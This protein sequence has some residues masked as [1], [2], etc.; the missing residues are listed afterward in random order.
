MA[1]VCYL[2]AALCFVYCLGVVASKAA[3][4]KFYLVWL[5]G[6]ALLNGVG[7]C[8]QRGLFWR[9]PGALRTGLA[10]L[11]CAGF[12]CLFGLL[13]LIGSTFEEKGEPNL[14][15]V[16]VLGAQMKE[17]GPSVALEKRLQK[18]YRYLSENPET[19]CVLSGGQ[20][21]N[22]P[23]SEAQGMYEYL[24][25]KGVDSKRLI[26]EDQSTN[27]VEN[28]QFSRKLI[29]EEIQKVGIVTSN[30]HVYR[31]LQLAKKQGFSDV[32]GISAAS[33]FYFLPNNVLRECFGIVKDRLYGNLNFF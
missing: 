25:K 14:P 32:V 31:S 13:I 4:T 5:I 28:L 21:S 15:Y 29:P 1:I 16:I 26:L 9:L 19:L 7:F 2:L 10:V 30:F 6:S 12:L 18:A 11:V 8:I 23:V 20:G 3:G 17:N 27:T 22:E 33:G 24:V